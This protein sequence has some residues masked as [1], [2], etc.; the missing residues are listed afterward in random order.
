MGIAVLILFGV[1][2]F[3]GIV[4][5]IGSYLYINDINLIQAFKKHCFKII[6]SLCAALLGFFIMYNKIGGK[7]MGAIIKNKTHAP[8]PAASVE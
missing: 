1:F 5:A 8:A 7:I 4:I 3:C 2:A 6:F